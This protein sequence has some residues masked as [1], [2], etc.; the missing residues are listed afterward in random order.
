MRVG[1]P[2]VCDGEVAE[3]LAVDGLDVERVL[4]LALILDLIIE[5]MG[6]GY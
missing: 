4:H 6:R 1:V 3:A 5:I 2:C